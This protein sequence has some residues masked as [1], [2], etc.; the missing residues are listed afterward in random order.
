MTT[1]SLPDLAAWTARLRHA[2]IPV[3]AAT[4]EELALLARVEEQRGDVDAHQLAEPVGRDPLMALKLM[5]DVGRLTARRRA[6]EGRG[7]PETVTAALVMMGVGP[8]FAAFEGTPTVEA[9]LAEWPPALA[10]LRRLTRRAHRGARFAL[11]FAVHRMD[12]DA[13]VLQLAALLHDFA[14]MLLCCHAPELALEIER[15][16]RA[17]PGLRSA[18]VQR[19]LL[20]IELPAL[21]QA[22]MRAWSLPELLV[23]VADDA[24]AEHPQVRSVELA[25]RLAR[26]TDE[27]WDNPA[28]ADDLADAAR[29]LNLSPAV[30]ES[31]LRSIDG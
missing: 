30:A 8:F 12:D 13:E 31:L 20:G 15:R 1:L 25:L 11:G 17:D 26:H 6:G 19:E 10:R 28:L 16:Q 9:L 18:A 2:A 23:R 21:Q 29:L 7:G 27:G 14:E 5:A 22:L 4:A 24:R 3:Q